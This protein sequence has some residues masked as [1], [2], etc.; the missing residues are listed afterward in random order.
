MLSDLYLTLSSKGRLILRCLTSSL[1]GTLWAGLEAARSTQL[2][3]IY[4]CFVKE[5]LLLPGRI[6]ADDE[7]NESQVC[8][9]CYFFRTIEV[10]IRTDHWYGL[11]SRD[12]CIVFENHWSSSVRLH[13]SNSVRPG[14]LWCSSYY[15]N[16]QRLLG[17][18]EDEAERR[19]CIVEGDRRTPNLQYVKRCSQVGQSMLCFRRHI[20]GAAIW[21]SVT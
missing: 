20:R 19:I 12:Q 8:Y 9:V 2:R 11:R 18:G 4:T 16:G 15:R 6:W 13:L 21:I 7:G 17:R 14:W 5:P 1:R 10:M 3:L